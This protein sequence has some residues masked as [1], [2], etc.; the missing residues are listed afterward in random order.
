MS[1]SRLLGD[2]SLRLGDVVTFDCAAWLTPARDDKHPAVLAEVQT[3]G[4]DVIRIGRAELLALRQRCDE[5]LTDNPAGEVIEGEPTNA[6]G[7]IGPGG[8]RVDIRASKHGA[9]A[10][11]PWGRDDD[12]CERQHWISDGYRYHAAAGV[13]DPPLAPHATLHACVPAPPD[14]SPSP[15]YARSPATCEGTGDVHVP[16]CAHAQ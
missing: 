14:V 5:L 11:D 16:G 4:S 13:P 2:G 12:A 7:V 10:L 8:R 3:D 6:Q 9:P 1:V 15:R